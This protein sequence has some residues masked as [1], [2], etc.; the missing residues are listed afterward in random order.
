MK[1]AFTGVSGV[2]QAFM[3]WSFYFLSDRKTFWNHRLGVI[4]V[5][6]DPVGQ[7]LDVFEATAN[8]IERRLSQ[9]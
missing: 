8:E 9:L 7:S 3:D 4:P 6:D 2:G 1:I 5:L